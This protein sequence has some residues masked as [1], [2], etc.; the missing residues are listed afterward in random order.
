MAEQLWAVVREPEWDESPHV[1]P[2]QSREEA[3]EWADE[4]L[5]QGRKVYA[6]RKLDMSIGPE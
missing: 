3:Q 2:F 1:G 5:S 6:I 4:Q